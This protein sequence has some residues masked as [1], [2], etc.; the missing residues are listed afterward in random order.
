MFPT[1]PIGPLRIQ[2]YGLF[3]LVAYWAGL[4]LAARLAPRHAIDRDHVYNVGFY[5]LIGGLVA[6]RLGH[7]VA[8]FDVYRV[9]PLQIISLSPGALLP[10]PGLIGALLVLIWYVR[11]H[12]LPAL[13]LVDSLAPGILLA[14]AIADIGAFLAGGRLGGLSDLPWSV[15]LFGVQRHPTVLYEA[16]ALAGLL[17][18]VL[19]LD[20]RRQHPSGWVALVALFGYAAVRLFLEPFYVAGVTIGDGWRLAQVGALAVVMLAGWLLG[21]MAGTASEGVRAGKNESS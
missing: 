17:A 2:T 5:A 13:P 6:A 4:G 9:S 15:E 11:R 14:L 16:G 19:W 20:A 18:L 7:I 21:R 8:F 10:L 3:L 12:Q 1:I